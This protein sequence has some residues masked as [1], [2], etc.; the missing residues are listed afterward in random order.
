MAWQ[1]MTV[2]GT[3]AFITL[4]ICCLGA[5]IPHGTE[6]LS[7]LQVRLATILI[8]LRMIRS[9]GGAVLS[10]DAARPARDPQ[11]SAAGLRSATGTVGGTVE[12]PNGR[13]DTGGATGAKQ[14]CI[15]IFDG[16]QHVRSVDYGA[17]A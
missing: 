1:P 15:Q 9:A 17:R 4:Y 8:L 12:A 7:A 10:G 5:F 2:G 13:V 6:R 11:T 16:L 14:P 3:F